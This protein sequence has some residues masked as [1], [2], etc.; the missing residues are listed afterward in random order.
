[1]RTAPVNGYVQTKAIPIFEHLSRNTK[2]LINEIKKQ[3]VPY[4]GIIRYFP[5]YFSRTIET[6]RYDIEFI[7]IFYS[8]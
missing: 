6:S 4:I 7:K 2:H 1:M 5:I 3:S 8:Y